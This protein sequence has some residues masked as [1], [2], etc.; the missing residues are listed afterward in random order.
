M[1]AKDGRP[2]DAESEYLR[3]LEADSN[4]ADVHYNLG[5]LYDDE[6][7]EEGKA[8][9]HYS[10]FL[11]LNPHSGEAETVVLSFLAHRA[12]HGR[13]CAAGPGRRSGPYTSGC[14]PPG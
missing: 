12:P 3:A 6:L 2:R 7:R 8:A 4:D 10:R 11:K 9:A 5:I 14:E 13:P 1:Y